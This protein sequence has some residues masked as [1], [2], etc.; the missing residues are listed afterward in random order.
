M[1]AKYPEKLYPHFDAF[2]AL[3]DNK[4][5]ILIWTAL[6]T[7]ANLCAVDVDKKFDAV[8]E[9]YYSL[10]S[11]PY[12]VTVVNVVVN[13]T[14]ITLAK[15]YLAPKITHELLKVEQISTT[16]HLTDECKRVIAEKTVESFDQVFKILD[17]EQ[18]R[19][20]ISFVKHHVNSSRKT[21][22][23]KAGLF[24]NRWTR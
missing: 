4:H 18:K 19:Q 6:G 23:S 16:P 20:V 21:L 5:R 22:R 14:K 10:I 7:I 3:L 11:D 1:S 2:T 17:S 13:S 8:F 24:L 15:P 12:L 9:K